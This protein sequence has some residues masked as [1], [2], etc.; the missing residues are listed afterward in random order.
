MKVSDRGYSAFVFIL[1]LIW[2][3]SAQEVTQG[4]SESLPYSPRV[5]AGRSTE[6]DKTSEGE[7]KSEAV[8]EKSV[9]LKDDQ[10]LE[11]SVSVLDKGGRFVTG[12]RSAD[13]TVFIDDTES[14]IHAFVPGGDSVN[15]V[16]LVD[17]SPSLNFAKRTRIVKFTQQLVDRIPPHK[18][19]MIV[20]FSWKMQVMT[21]LTDNR[22]IIAKAIK[23]LNSIGGTAIYETIGDLFV[24]HLP[25]MPGQEAVI[26]I[27]DGINNVS[28]NYD[29]EH[30]L[31]EVEKSDAMI[32]PIY[33]DPVDQVMFGKKK[34]PKKPR[35]RMSSVMG[36]SMYKDLPGI[37]EMA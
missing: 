9:P 34:K 26:I 36:I 15:L 30:S 32:F 1:I 31:V 16:I 17:T 5:F 25:N 3:I 18:K 19:I 14:E 10:Y 13:F 12:L 2:S 21:P 20:Q 6:P 22:A 8:E 23:K 11:L 28:W 37:K 24:T 29:Y 4:Y 7:K 27:T 35:W 33:F